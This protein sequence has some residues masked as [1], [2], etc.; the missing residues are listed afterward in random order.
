MG[1]ARAH[2]QML[3]ENPEAIMK[4]ASAF[5][6]DHARQDG[7]AEDPDF[8]IYSGGF[9]G[10]EDKRAMAQIRAAHPAEL[11][12]WRQPFRD[13]R[14]SEMLF[15]Y[16][17]RNYPDSL[18]L[19]E[20]QRWQLHCQDALLRAPEH[21]GAGVSWAEFTA[22]LHRLQQETLDAAQLRLLEDIADYGQRLLTPESLQRIAQ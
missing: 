22:E 20:R 10:A 4:V 15:R 13:A 18:A 3:A 14:L 11:A 5:D 2:W 7:P 17:A 19:D 21:P 6:R 16:R 8:M 12:M 1:K 9:F